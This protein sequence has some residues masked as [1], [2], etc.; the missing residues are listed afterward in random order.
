MPKLSKEAWTFIVLATASAIVLF[1]YVNL[2][3]RIGN[4]FFFSNNDPQFQD[5]KEISHLFHR[6]DSLLVINASGRISSK[7]YMQKIHD[8]ST[9]L[10]RVGGVSEVKSIAMGPSSLEDALKGPLWSRLLIAKD[11][12]STNIII[13]IN[14]V[15]SQAIIPPIKKLVSRYSQKG[16]RLVMSGPSYIVDMISH[17]L[18]RDIRV[19]TVLVLAIFG[20]VTFFIFRSFGILLGA[21]VSCVSASMWTLMITHMLHITIGLLTANLATI[22]FVITLSHIIFFTYNWKY[23]LSLDGPPSPVDEAMHLTFSPSFWS[24]TTTTLGFLSLLFVPAQPLKELGAG[25]VVGALMAISVAYG[26]YP[27]F[28][29]LVPPSISKNNALDRYQQKMERSLEKRK[30]QTV[31]GIFLL[32]FIALPGIWRANTDP[33]LFS[34]FAK[35]T[36]LRK[37]LVYIDHHGGSSPLMLVVRSASG[38]RLDTDRAYDKL[39]GLQKSLENYDPVGSVISL[40]VLMAQARES[41]F[42]AKLPPWSGLLDILRAKQFNNIANSF[43]TTDD[44][45]GLF[46]LRMKESGRKIPRLE[47]IHRIKKMAVAHGLIPV[48]VGG[49]YSLQG[50]LA[51]LVAS[52]IIFGLGQLI[53]IFSF[54]AWMVARSLKIALAIT[55]SIC[56]I[57][58]IVLGM[59][60]WFGIP[61]DVISAPACN[62]ALGLG[63]DSMIHMVRAYRRQKHPEHKNAEAW[64]RI[65]HRFWQPVL[66]FTLVMVLGFGIFMFSEFPS[67]QRFGAAVVFGTL[68]AAMTALFIMPT[69]AQLRTGIF[70]RSWTR[71]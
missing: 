67:T 29:R 44:S 27:A 20:L 41:S 9:S 30:N 33:S 61:V 38:Q 37:N 69:T 36:L 60:G 39:W 25:G 26:V 46:I 57:P 13:F 65:R 54:I 40:P 2:V 4:N 11:Q 32:F 28:L 34:F 71:S 31:I 58:V 52:S 7:A 64:D 51:K 17:N 6:R 22:V 23:V 45:K 48:L 42:L 68:I 10:S 8:L 24:M 70:K 43:I 56:I 62:I 19:F 66:T 47:V 50:H 12:K 15:Y 21:V 14:P 5:E 49:I 59:I 53:L 55:L 18:L 63:I 3:P 35:N 16:F 1:N